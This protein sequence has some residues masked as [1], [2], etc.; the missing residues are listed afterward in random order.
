LKTQ[1]KLSFEEKIIFKIFKCIQV[2]KNKN[3]KCPIDSKIKKKK[4]KTKK[5]RHAKP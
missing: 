3:E 2:K 4:G 5:T 1:I